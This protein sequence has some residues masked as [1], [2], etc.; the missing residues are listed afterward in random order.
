MGASSERFTTDG[1]NGVHLR[2]LH[3]GDP[4]APKLV[5]LHGGGANATWW[6]H[7]APALAARFHVLALDFRGHGESDYPDER[8]VGAFNDDLEALLEHL[9]TREV[10]LVGHSMGGHVALDHVSRH[11]SIRSLVLLDIVLGAGRRSRRAARLALLLR[12]TYA[13]EQ[14]AIRRFRFVPEARYASED[15]R[16][17]LAAASLRPEPNGRFGYAFDPRWFGVPSRPRP[18]L[19]TIRCRTV[20]VRGCESELLTHDG[21]VGFADELVDARLIEIPRAGHHVQIDQPARVQDALTS[22]LW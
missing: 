17:S 12:R 6:S 20:L 10:S 16:A 8:V 3:W 13:T 15:L 4:T 18:D 5:L 9:G 14:E 21:A 19:S 1:L 22:F 2:A 7:L 11:E